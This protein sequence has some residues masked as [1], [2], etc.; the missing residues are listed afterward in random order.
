V[1]EVLYSEIDGQAL[2]RVELVA[3]R[4]VDGLTLE[5]YTGHIYFDAAVFSD[6]FPERISS[7]SPPFVIGSKDSV[8]IIAAFQG[9]EEGEPRFIGRFAQKL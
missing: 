6:L 3:S 9:M 2:I 4:W 8:R 7:R 1:G 5:S